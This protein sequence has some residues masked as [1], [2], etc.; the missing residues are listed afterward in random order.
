[1]G[2]PSHVTGA[3]NT[4]NHCS[5]KRMQTSTTY[6]TRAKWQNAVR[7]SERSQKKTNIFNTFGRRL[8]ERASW[9]RAPV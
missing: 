5:V 3:S 6:M 1:M 8:F 2:G 7:M 4:T 9:Q